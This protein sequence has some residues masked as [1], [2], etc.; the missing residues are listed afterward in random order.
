MIGYGRYPNAQVEGIKTGRDRVKLFNPI[1][2]WK[3]SALRYHLPSSS[4]TS[5]NSHQYSGKS[6]IHR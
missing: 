3:P 5:T 6:L 1:S 4:L 2:T